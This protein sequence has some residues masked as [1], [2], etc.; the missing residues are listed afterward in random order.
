MLQA[1]SFCEGMLDPRPTI[2]W[3]TTS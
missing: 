2:N 1:V 3:R